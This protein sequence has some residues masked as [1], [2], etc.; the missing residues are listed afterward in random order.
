MSL[1]A[2]ASVTAGSKCTPRSLP[3]IAAHSRPAVPRNSVQR[4]VVRRS[5]RASLARVGGALAVLF[6]VVGDFRT[7]S[8][9]ERDNFDWY[10]G[11]LQT[12]AAAISMNVGP[13]VRPA[14]APHAGP[15]GSCRMRSLP[16]VH[17]KH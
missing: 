9:F 3:P 12:V 15:R 13:D 4:L 2:R 17:K 8:L 14:A 6:H 11:N 5:L 10:A 16:V 7:G 1:A